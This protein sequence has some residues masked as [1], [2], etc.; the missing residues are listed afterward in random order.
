LRKQIIKL[1]KFNIPI[2]IDI[3][4]KTHQFVCIRQALSE[5]W[6]SSDL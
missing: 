4:I 1:Q 6:I 5:L 3:S 2:S